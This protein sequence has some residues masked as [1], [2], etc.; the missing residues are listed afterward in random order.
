MSVAARSGARSV[1]VSVADTGIGIAPEDL[2]YVF[3]RF[4]R[5]D[6]SRAGPRAARGWAWPL[7]SS[8]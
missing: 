3:E 1:E 7:P 6:R 2:P 8:W 4:Y 5:A